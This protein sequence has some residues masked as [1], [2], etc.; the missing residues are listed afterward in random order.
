MMTP[1]TSQAPESRNSNAVPLPTPGVASLA[2]EDR[3]LLADAE[4]ALA[5]RP[6]ISMSL[7]IGMSMLLCFLL[8]AG[9]VVASM[10][11]VSRVGTLQEFLDKASTYALEVE[12]TRRYE[13][14]YLLYGTGLDDALTQVQ[15]AHNQLH[16]IK[17]SMV[18]VTGPQVFERMEENLEQYDRSLERLAELARQLSAASQDERKQNERTQVEK[19]LRQH[20]AQIIADATDLLERERLRLRTA[21]RTSWIVAASSLLFIMLAMALVTFTLTRQVSNPLRRFT[22]YTERIAA[23]DF[24]PIL[25]ARRYRDEFSRLAVAINRMLFRLK[26]REAQLARH[27][28][29]AAVGTLTAGI[30][31]ELNNPLNNI[32]LNAE[33]L[34][35]GL[36]R[37][38]D[39]QKLKMLADVVS[40]VERASATVRNLLDFTRVEKPVVVS[41]SVENV[42]REARRLVANEAEINRVEFNFA[43]PPDLP[44]VQ[45]NPRDLQQVFL[46]LFLNA[47]QAMPNGG[48]LT[49]RGKTTD[50][51]AL[52]VEVTDT[53]VGIP[54]ENIGSVFDPFFTTKEVGAGTGLGLAVSYG[55]V[56]KHNGT[57]TVRSK[58]GE[59][60]TF[61]VRLPI[62]SIEGGVGASLSSHRG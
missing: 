56:E 24:S 17:A 57:I 55:I 50:D 60:T 42:V 15:A 62:S 52:E 2:D 11:L 32:S 48:V 31:H 34:H 39:D 30:A 43:L 19:E 13:K 6:N 25:P 8:V 16:S 35:E 47:I 40:Q 4:R 46:N 12:N 9:V 5:D 10:V 41:L 7:R 33:A 61:V 27:S 18:E 21:I 49:V 1:L 23:G 14:N 59:G 26:D 45:G 44:K 51:K 58:V 29:M 53:G 37:Y 22:G 36:N 54:D 28:R 38:T 3:R 20:G